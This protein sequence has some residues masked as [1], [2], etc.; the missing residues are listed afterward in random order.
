MKLAMNYLSGIDGIGI[1]QSISF[2]FFF[3]IFLLILYYVFTT[4]KSYYTG[5]SQMPLEDDAEADA[6]LDNEI[7]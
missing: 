4:K 2:V 7:K 6:Y 1:T 3:G 5:I